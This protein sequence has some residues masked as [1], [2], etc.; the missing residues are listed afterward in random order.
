[1]K[2]TDAAAEVRALAVAYCDGLHAADHAV[3]EDMCDDR[4][5]MTGVTG[6]GGTL[7]F[8]KAAFVARIEARAPHEGEQTY[9]IHSVDVAG[10]EIARVHLSVDVHPR[11]Y[12]DHLGFVRVH[13]TWKLITK[14][15]RTESGPALEA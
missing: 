6:S 10:G 5:A 13:G 3:F 2:D 7:F 4:F 15:Y 9:E 14:V 8:D 12:E 11:R 1:M